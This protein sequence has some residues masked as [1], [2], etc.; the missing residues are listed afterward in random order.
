M[1]LES[2]SRESWHR[3]KCYWNAK[4]E[5]ADLGRNATGKRK[6]KELTEAEHYWNARAERAD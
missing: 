5:R 6:P 2:E 3:Q 4:A 1:L